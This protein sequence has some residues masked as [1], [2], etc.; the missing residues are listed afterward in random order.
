MIL[1]TDAASRFI[2]DAWR[3][4][5]VLVIGAPWRQYRWNVLLVATWRRVDDERIHEDHVRLDGTN[6]LYVRADLVPHI[7][8][9]RLVLDHH[10]VAGLWPGITI[11]ELEPATLSPSTV[12]PAR[13]VRH[14]E[15]D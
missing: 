12:S 6:G 3:R 4:G 15:G 1:I 2:H 9:R 14:G 5:R 7:R 11:R 13:S 8:R 10:S